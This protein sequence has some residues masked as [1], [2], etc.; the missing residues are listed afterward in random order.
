MK[1]KTIHFND[2]Q[3]QELDNLIELLGI[4]GYGD[5]PKALAFSVTFTLQALEKDYKVLP[6]LNKDDLERWF[7]SV[8]KINSKKIMEKKIENLKNGVLSNTHDE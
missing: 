1:K 7:Y 4:R 8:K 5:I 6:C 2:K 3:L